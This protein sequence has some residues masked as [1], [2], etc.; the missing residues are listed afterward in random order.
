MIHPEA[1]SLPE[2]A[3]LPGSSRSDGWRGIVP[4]K[5]D[6]CVKQGAKPKGTAKSTVFLA[7]TAPDRVLGFC[8]TWARGVHWAADNE[9]G[10]VKNDARSDCPCAAL[11]VAHRHPGWVP[12]AAHLPLG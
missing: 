7:G 6:T 8:A 3:T 9:S 10:E 2:R 12:A 1:L 11:D 5:P 4:V